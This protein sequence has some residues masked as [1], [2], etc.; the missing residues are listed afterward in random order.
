MKNKYIL[1]AV[2]VTLFASVAANAQQG[3]G[4]NNPDPSSVIDM[5]SAKR[6]VLV[7]R[8]ALTA[9]NVATPVTAPAEALLVYNEA[10]AG[11][12]PYEVKPGFYYWSVDRW[13]RI[14]NI[15]DIT[16]G[17]ISSTD[18]TVTG[19]TDATFKNV[20]LDIKDGAITTDKIASEAVTEDKMKAP[21]IT[22]TATIRIP[23]AQNDGTVAYGPFPAAGVVGDNLTAA[24]DTVESI[25][26]VTGGTGAVL[27]PTSLRVKDG[28]ITEVK[29]ADGAVTTAKIGA[30]AVTNAKLADNAVQT[31]NIAAGAVETSDVK[32]AAVTTVKIEDAAVTAVKLAD[33][34]VTAAKIDSSVAGTGLKQNT[35]NGSLEVD[36]ASFDGDITSTDLTVTGGDNATFT[37]VTLD[38]K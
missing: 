7:P 28:G 31:E 2:L 23:I 25:E 12:D 29:L 9:T 11:A 30:D 27:V 24:A 10:T 5:V 18:L 34:A 38:I 19:G 8:V 20:T 1:S 33:D 17:T 37:D 15:E 22:G 13:I 32:D 36:A 6:G 26:V 4:T 35:T 21:E 14:T 3:F 16:K